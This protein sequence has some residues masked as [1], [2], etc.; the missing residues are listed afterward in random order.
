MLEIEQKYA[1]AD[2]TAIKEKLSNWGVVEWTLRQEAD[3]YLNAPDR[4]FAQTKEAFR[5]RRVAEM[6]YL[7]YKGPRIDPNVKIRPELELRV[8]DGEQS[9][10]EMLQLFE[11]LGYRRVAVGSQI[12]R[13]GQL[14]STG[15]YD[16][17][18]LG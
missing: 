4:D 14:F 6:N 13:D 3:H 2:F 9:A 16:H 18:L 11:H 12:A 8:A 15:L 17:C 1:N 10:E 7:T 5:L